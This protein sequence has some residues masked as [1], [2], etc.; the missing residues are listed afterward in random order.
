MPL[1]ADR[2][3]VIVPDLRGCGDSEKAVAGYEKENLANDLHELLK[4]LDVDSSIS[5]ARTSV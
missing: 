4:H 3:T 2:F 1:L 5:S